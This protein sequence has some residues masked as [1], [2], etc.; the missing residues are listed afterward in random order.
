ML[1]R[2]EQTWLEP[3]DGIPCYASWYSIRPFLPNVIA[4]AFLNY[5]DNIINLES[6]P[7]IISY[8]NI[9]ELTNNKLVEKSTDF[10]SFFDRNV[11]S[12][13]LVKRK[14]LT[15]KNYLNKIGNC[16]YDTF[17]DGAKFRKISKLITGTPQDVVVPIEVMLCGNCGE[18]CEELLPE[19]MKVLAEIDKR[20]SEE[21]A[22]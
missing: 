3:I 20:N 22:S 6:I 16:G 12:K 21:S 17:V 7:N 9:V 14:V 4:P 13:K 18:I 5:K 1:F 2:S 11:N 10:T 8:I 15:R 19:Q